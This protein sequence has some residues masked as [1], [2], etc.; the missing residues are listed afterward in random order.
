[1]SSAASDK[2][3][4]SPAN[5]AAKGGDGAEGIPTVSLVLVGDTA[6]GKTCLITN[7]LHNTYSDAYEP[8][9]LDKYKGVKSISRR[10]V[11]VEIHD[12]SGEQ[13]LAKNRLPLYETCDVLMLCVAIDDKNSFDS[14]DRWVEEIS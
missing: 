11:D 12:T 9:V 7:Y 4:A 10:Q 13:N 8:T 5:N 1:M 6:V 2:Q 3:A 14:I